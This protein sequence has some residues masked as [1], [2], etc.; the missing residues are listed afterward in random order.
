MQMSNVGCV[1]NHLARWDDEVVNAV[2]GSLTIFDITNANTFGLSRA[3]TASKT[4]SED[5]FRDRQLISVAFLKSS[6]RIS[7]AVYR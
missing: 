6:G 2:H 4:E 1:S 5:A 7:K 3:C